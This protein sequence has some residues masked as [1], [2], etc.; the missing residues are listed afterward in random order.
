VFQSVHSFGEETIGGAE[1]PDLTVL[2]TMPSVMALTAVVPAKDRVAGAVTR[3]EDWCLGSEAA[4]KSL[5]NS[6]ALNK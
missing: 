5:G 6:A 4:S 3:V 2:D 1:I